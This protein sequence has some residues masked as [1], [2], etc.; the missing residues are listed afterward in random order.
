MCV[1]AQIGNYW[2]F[3]SPRGFNFINLKSN[4][5][6]KQSPQEHRI[7]KCMRTLA[8]TF[9]VAVICLCVLTIATPESSIVGVI[10]ALIIAITSVTYIYI[11]KKDQDERIN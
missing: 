3:D 7:R 9:Y 1:D 2:G 10:L 11:Y 6:E 5:M 8:S 4:Q